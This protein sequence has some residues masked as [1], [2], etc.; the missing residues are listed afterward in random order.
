MAN[1]EALPRLM[2]EC[3]RRYD[4]KAVA[5]LFQVVENERG[6]EST[7]GAWIGDGARP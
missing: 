5:A 1:Q 6:W 3:D 7:D 2:G 4:R